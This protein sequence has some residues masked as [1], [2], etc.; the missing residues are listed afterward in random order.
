MHLWQ[1]RQHLKQ[2]PKQPDLFPLSY[3]HSLVKCYILADGHALLSCDTATQAWQFAQR[4]GLAALGLLASCLL[5]HEAAKP[6]PHELLL[7]LVPLCIASMV[8]NIASKSI[9][10]AILV[11]EIA[12]IYLVKVLESNRSMALLQVELRHFLRL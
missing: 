8:V 2:T 12:A 4:G 9:E 10:V 6:L 5:G 11:L 7:L 1:V 3:G